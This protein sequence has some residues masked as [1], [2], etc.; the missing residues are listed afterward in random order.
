[1]MPEA[2][3]APPTPRRAVDLVDEK[4][5]GPASAEKTDGLAAAGA[6]PMKRAKR[7]TNTGADRGCR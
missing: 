7:E 2:A 4:T 6:P 5:D 1:M 3:H